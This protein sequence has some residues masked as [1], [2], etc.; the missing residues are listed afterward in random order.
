M[1]RLRSNAL[2]GGGQPRGDLG[3]S[4]R[5]TGWSTW[6]TAITTC[7]SKH[8]PLQQTRRAESGGRIWV[9]GSRQREERHMR[10]Q[11]PHR[12]EGLVTSTQPVTGE[13][14]PTGEPAEGGETACWA[15]LVCPDCG[16]M[17]SEGHRRGCGWGPA[18]QLRVSVA[19][20][21]P[22]AGVGDRSPVLLRAGSSARPAAAAHR[23]DD[24]CRDRDMHHD[25]A[26]GGRCGGRG[27]QGQGQ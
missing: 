12:Q 19:V 4:A 6:S 5:N 25:Q 18:E 27:A 17:V 22:S 24:D 10:R 7:S 20:A 2:C 26:G 8:D 23:G 16:A 1:P 11:L 14:A 9:S 13:A 3:G 21:A 15:H